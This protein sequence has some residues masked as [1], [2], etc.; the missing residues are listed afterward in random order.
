MKHH[1]LHWLLVYFLLLSRSIFYY[2]GLLMKISFKSYSR[3]PVKM[4]LNLIKKIHSFN[5][6]YDYTLWVALIFFFVLAK[7]WMCNYLLINY[8]FSV[9]WLLC[10]LILIGILIKK[11]LIKFFVLMW[12][13][14]EEKINQVRRLTLLCSFIYFLKFFWTNVAAVRFCEY[15]Y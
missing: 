1:D 3:T 12:I 4:F 8:I 10:C 7:P 6:N 11:F 15:K 14:V 9:L 5:W 2:K 13:V